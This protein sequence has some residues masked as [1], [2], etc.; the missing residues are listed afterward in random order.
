MKRN[1][2]SINPGHTMEF[3]RLN[4]AIYEKNWKNWKKL[5]KLKQYWK[6]KSCNIWKEGYEERWNFNNSRAYNGV[7]KPRARTRE[8]QKFEGNLIRVNDI[9]FKTWRN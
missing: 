2:F 1:E 5:E 9:I 8:F 4:H 7:S 6:T 3:Q